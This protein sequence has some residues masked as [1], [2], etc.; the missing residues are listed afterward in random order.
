MSSSSSVS[1]EASTAVFLP[2]MESWEKTS[3][4]RA[5]TL[6]TNV[7]IINALV[8]VIFYHSFATFSPV[9][10]LTTALVSLEEHIIINLYVLVKNFRKQDNRWGLSDF[11]KLAISVA[12]GTC[13]AFLY[14]NV[15]YTASSILM[16][17][18]VPSYLYY[19]INT[20][21]INVVV[22]IFLTY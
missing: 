16:Y 8:H 5:A 21:T 18:S 20:A 14:M 19:A 2:K 15:I 17:V 9:I 22:D 3:L 1:S 4:K 6:F 13:N 7:Y 10:S 12:I 11:E